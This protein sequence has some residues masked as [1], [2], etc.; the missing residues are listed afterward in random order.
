LDG[1]DDKVLTVGFL[2]WWWGWE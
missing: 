1:L 2:Y